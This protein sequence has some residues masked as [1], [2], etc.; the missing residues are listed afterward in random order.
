MGGSVGRRPGRPQT[1]G[2][3]IVMMTEQSRRHAVGLQAA[4]QDHVMTCA[5]AGRSCASCDIAAPVGGTIREACAVGD[6]EAL[7]QEV[8]AVAPLA[9]A[10]RRDC[11]KGVDLLLHLMSVTREGFGGAADATAGAEIS[12]CA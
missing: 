11:T 4:L 12:R 2:K 3:T 1:L 8:M 6:A 7:W 5:G 9:M 10:C